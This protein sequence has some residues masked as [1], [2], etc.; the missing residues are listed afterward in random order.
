MGKTFLNIT[1]YTWRQTMLQ[2]KGFIGTG[3]ALLLV[4]V[5]INLAVPTETLEAQRRRATATP[6]PNTTYYI[7]ANA[8]GREC[9][10]L[11]CDVIETFVAGE[12]V[13]VID[14]AEGDTVRGSDVWY[15]VRI[16]RRVTVFVHSS[17]LTDQKPVAR[18]TQRRATTA[19]P[20]T[21]SVPQPTQQPVAWDCNGDRYNCDSFANR[22]E[23]MSYFNACP[24]DPSR[25][26]GDNNGVPCES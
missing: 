24:G 10:A 21:T 1:Q 8:N 6:T 25:L 19:I 26:D 12:S 16:S 18:P 4:L 23:L 5:I 20:G 11:D 17:L 15:E 7:T 3:L 14:E 22:N 13:E 2:T 9:P